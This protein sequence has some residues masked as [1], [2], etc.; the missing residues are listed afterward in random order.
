LSESLRLVVV[1]V[2]TREFLTVVVVDCRQP[3]VMLAA[4]ISLKDGA[5]LP[6]GHLNLSSSKSGRDVIAFRNI[7]EASSFFGIGCLST[8]RHRQHIGSELST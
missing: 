7:P 4:A 8:D 2:Y 6:S 3:V 5:S 1:Y